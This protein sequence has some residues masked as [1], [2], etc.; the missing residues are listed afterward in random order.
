M[1]AS[2]VTAGEGQLCQAT[3]TRRAVRACAKTTPRRYAQ[4]VVNAISVLLVLWYCPGPAASDEL[5]FGHLLESWCAC[6]DLPHA[7]AKGIDVHLRAQAKIQAQAVNTWY[8]QAQ[9]LIMCYTT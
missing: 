5:V 1:A 9:A 8:K 3:A 6:V 2:V 7:D 4:A